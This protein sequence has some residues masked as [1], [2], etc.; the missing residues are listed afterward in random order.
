MTI[1]NFAGGVK[2]LNCSQV[3]K[4]ILPESLHRLSWFLN[5][6]VLLGLYYIKKFIW[7][8]SENN[9]V[10]RV[11][12]F[13]DLDLSSSLHTQSYIHTCIHTNLYS[14]KIVKTNLIIVIIIIFV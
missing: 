14:A 5:S 10:I 9:T 6:S 4:C 8:S 3:L 12:P 2:I 11:D 13:C 1:K 7:I